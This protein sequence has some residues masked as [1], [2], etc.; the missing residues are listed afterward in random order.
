MFRPLK[1]SSQLYVETRCIKLHKLKLCWL[2]IYIII[3]HKKYLES[4]ETWC[5]RRMEISWTDS[6]KK[7]EVLH[8]GQS[9]KEH[10]SYSEKKE[11]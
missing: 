7:E 10:S 8:K 3:K 11:S 4:F 2:F 1:S 9:G 6:V 5:W